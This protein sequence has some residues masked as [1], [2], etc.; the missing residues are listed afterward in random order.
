MT[1]DQTPNDPALHAFDFD[2]DFMVAWEGLLWLYDLQAAHTA[3]DRDWVE[4][5]LDMLVLWTRFPTEASRALVHFETLLNRERFGG[6]GPLLTKKEA[7]LELRRHGIRCSM[8]T[9]ERAV[10][11]GE[12]YQ[13]EVRGQK[14]ILPMPK[15][16]F[17]PQFWSLINGDSL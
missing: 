5:L 7:A 6:V 13:V 3:G 11:D 12:L 9:L 10:R 1:D 17:E 4:R 16:Y 8:K 14:R 2:D 15:R